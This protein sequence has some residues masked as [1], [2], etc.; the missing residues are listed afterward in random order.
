MSPEEMLSIFDGD[1]ELAEYVTKKI[2]GHDEEPLRTTVDLRNKSIMSL[3]N[4][5][6]I[7][8]DSKHQLEPILELLIYDMTMRITDF[9]DDTGLIKIKH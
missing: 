8:K 5:R 3:K 1:L 7:D 9:Y 2:R 6:K 4:V